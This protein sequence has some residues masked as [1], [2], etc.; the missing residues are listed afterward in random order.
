MVEAIFNQ[1]PEV[2]RSALVGIGDKGNQ[3]AVIIIEPKKKVYIKDRKMQEQ[4]IR[5]LLLIGQKSKTSSVIK[6]FLFHPNFPV[7]IRHNAKIQRDKLAVW[8][9]KRLGVKQNN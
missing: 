4:L 1:H 2:S 6:E 5:E 7:D 9:E 3:K 8:C